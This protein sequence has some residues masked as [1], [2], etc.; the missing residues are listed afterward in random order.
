MMTTI[1]AQNHNLEKL[2]LES[3]TL[4]RLSLPLESGYVLI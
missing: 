1:T 2:I 3:K 4:T